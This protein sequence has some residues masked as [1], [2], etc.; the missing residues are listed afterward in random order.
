[1][2]RE[3]CYTHTNMW[4]ATLERCFAEDETTAVYHNSDPIR[5]SMPIAN[6]D[7]AILPSV[8]LHAGCH[9]NGTSIVSL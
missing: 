1:M 2:D 8:E 3:E 6:F 7:L 5:I 4:N 9:G